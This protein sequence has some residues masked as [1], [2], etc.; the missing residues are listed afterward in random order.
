VVLKVFELAEAE[1]GYL[2]YDP[3][4]ELQ[5]ALLPVPV[6]PMITNLLR[7]STISLN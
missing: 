2:S 6:E 1:T 4:N 5:V 3:H 7:S